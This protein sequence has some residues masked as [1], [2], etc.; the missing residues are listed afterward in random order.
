MFEKVLSC[1]GPTTL[2]EVKNLSS[3]R[4][5]VE[6]SVNRSSNVTDA[7]AREMNRGITSCEQVK[8]K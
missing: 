8:K 3:K 1:D 7:I 5:A 2:Q 4:K 6:E